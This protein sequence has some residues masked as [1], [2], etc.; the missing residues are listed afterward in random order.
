[1]LQTVAVGNKSIKQFL[2]VVCLA[3]QIDVKK[4]IHSFCQIMNSGPQDTG[5]SLNKVMSTGTT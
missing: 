1:M 4:G 5:I 3:I 2:N